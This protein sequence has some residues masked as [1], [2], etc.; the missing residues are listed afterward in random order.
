MGCLLNAQQ[1]RA[2]NCATGLP[3]HWLRQVTTL[4]LLNRM[5]SLRAMSIRR[6]RPMDAPTRTNK[7][8]RV[9]AVHRLATMT[10]NRFDHA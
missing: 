4:G 8:R 2:A 5:I 3:E 7:V 10:A 6:G 1:L 9:F